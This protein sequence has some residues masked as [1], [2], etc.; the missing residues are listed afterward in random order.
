M[1][2]V[3]KGKSQEH[4][5]L[6]SGILRGD[7]RTSAAPPW[8]GVPLC[9]IVAHPDDETIG[10]GAQLSNDATVVVATDG[11]PRN[12][13][14]ATA[15]G[16]G[17]SSEYAAARAREFRGAMRIAGVEETSLAHLGV[18][19]QEAAHHITAIA[20]VLAEVIAGRGIRFA[21]THAYEGGHPDHDAVACAAYASCRLLERRGHAVSLYEM[22]LYRQGVNRELRQTFAPH[23]TAHETAAELSLFLD[24]D[25]QLRKQRMLACY[26]TQRHTLSGF[27]I[28]TERFRPM[29]R[30]DFTALPNRGALLY[31]RRDWGVR[32]G[33]EWRELAGRALSELDLIK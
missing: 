6:S 1:D 17:T 12:L 19:D 31:E 11:A 3:I 27:V 4:D 24:V 26:T 2:V 22:P 20:R 25:A 29:P 8:C 14:D 15:C 28:G 5:R 23:E 32:T 13:L 7:S 10:C 30:H 33:A 18:P 9:V 21:I 16:F